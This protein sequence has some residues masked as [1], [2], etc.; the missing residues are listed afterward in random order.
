M[1]KTIEIREIPD[2][3]VNN[4]TQLVT[5]N[6]FKVSIISGHG[7]AYT[8]TDEHNTIVGT[9]ATI[10]HQYEKEVGSWTYCVT[11]SDGTCS[12]NPA[13]LTYS[14]IN[15]PVP[16]PTIIVDNI[17]G[18]TNENA[19]KFLAEGD[20]EIHWYKE[21]DMSTIVAVGGSY[22]P[23]DITSAGTYRFYV[24]QSDGTC[25]GV[26]AIATLNMHTTPLPQVSGNMPVCEN[27][28]LVLTADGEVL[29]YTDETLNHADAIA[30]VHFVSYAEAGTYSL[31]VTRQSEYCTSNP[32]TLTIQINEIPAEPVIKYENVCNGNDVIFTATGEDILW[33]KNGMVTETEDPSTL[34]EK[35]ILP[36][37]ITVEAT[38]TI[39]GCTS[40]RASATA[41]I[42][43][44][45][46]NPTANNVTIC[47]YNQIEPVSVI[48]QGN[49]D[50]TWYNDESLSAVIATSTTYKPTEK[51]TQTFYV[52]QTVNGCESEPVTVTLRVNEKPGDVVFKETRDIQA[53][54]GTKVTIN[55][56][57]A[58][59][60]FWYEQG[61]DNPIFTGR[62][63]TVPTT[64]VGEY[65]YYATQTDAAG[66]VSDKTPKKVTLIAGPTFALIEKQ[67]TICEY[68]KPGRLIVTRQNEN[69]SVSWIAPSGETIGSIGDTLDI[70]ESLNLKPGT[71]MF[72][73]RTTVSTC[74]FETRKE[75][76][77]KYVIH[78]K[79]ADPTL[80]KTAF[81]FD[82]QSITLS[83]NAKNP[84]WYNED[85][86]I[87]SVYSPEYMTPYSAV[88]NYSIKMTQN[89]NECTSDTVTLPF[90][91]S[92]LP[93]PTITGENKVCEGANESYV[94]TKSD[95]DNTI[96]W[97][98]TGD[99]VI[100]ELS[101]YGSGFVRSIDWMTE[102]FDTIFVY[103]TNKYGCRGENE[104]PI[105]I[106]SAPD[107][108][109]LAES[110][111]QEGV[112][113]FTNTS[114]S[115]ILNNKGVEK[116]YH[117]DYYWDFGRT[118]DTARVLQNAEVFEEKYR[119]GD[120]YAKMTAINEFGCAT[121]VTNPFFVDVAHALYV[122]TAFA[123]MSVSGEIRVFKPKGFN[124][125][126]F[127]I[128]IY[129]A[130]NNLVYYSEGVDDHGGPVCE[131]DGKVDGK[132]MQCGTYRY[133]IEVTFEDH[134]EDNMKI[135]QSVKP[136][137]GN[138]VLTR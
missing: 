130:W 92:A 67:D 11:E 23:N 38:Q 26:P 68:E 111:G 66:C 117:V 104:Y 121:S 87:L 116:E 132:M 125:S 112:I 48:V 3:Y 123:P 76:A 109:F 51:E 27:E 83:T 44:I 86:S 54:E 63:F 79:P 98:V 120:Y 55:A 96:K 138:V 65:T 53:C 36:G 136:I 45:P 15:C 115:Q 29:W 103:E 49:A 89:I 59:T 19:P 64:E 84:I 113:T 90:L 30:P 124:C 69:E 42:Y 40:P 137:W 74:S 73:A 118:T 39:N 99:R 60:I 9:G 12:S 52:T 14:I 119:Y 34:I 57:S 50:V 20:Y 18:C 58:N 105:E 75:T 17:D 70:P 61:D 33:Y 32:V 28:Q 1:K 21:N 101:S 43:A 102:G 85:N 81:C 35:T 37:T 22:T 106:L 72:K 71:Y 122:P 24:T 126:T 133:K 128:W 13:C 41:E 10:E 7:G 97:Q 129:D 62:T 4:I 93:T 25:E 47:E 6:E 77:L 8:W 5:S 91:I 127:K 135:T 100:Y 108:Q 78:P 56:S 16:A 80:K 131:W 110:L 88:G 114:E 46:N 2:V 94:V 134:S 107:A 82:G 31:Y 95:E